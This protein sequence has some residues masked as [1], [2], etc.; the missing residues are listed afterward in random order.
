[1]KTLARGK[2]DT[3][4]FRSATHLQGRCKDGEIGVVN[5]LYAPKM[6]VR[7]FERMG[8]SGTKDTLTSVLYHSKQ[9]LDTD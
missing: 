3:C 1:M 2:N 8:W 9:G 6:R 5:K 7:M 4:A